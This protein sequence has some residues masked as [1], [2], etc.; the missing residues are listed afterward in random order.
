M[1]LPNGN[2]AYLDIL[3]LGGG[4]FRSGV[5]VTDHHSDPIEF[6]CTQVVHPNT[7][8]KALWGQRLSRHLVLNVLGY[9]LMESIENSLNV[10]FVSRHDFLEMRNKLGIPLILLSTTD[11]HPLP[12]YVEV[13]ETFQSQAKQLHAF[14][15]TK[16]REDWQIARNAL[17]VLAQSADVM[18][19]FGRI[20]TSLK[21]VTDQEKK[22]HGSGN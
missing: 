18:E 22:Q 17:S 2:I 9:P 20:A 15:H 5:L 21:L 13:A 16:F 10:L 1:E 4:S 19:P 14:T 8:Q 6:R 12:S 11:T 7:L 3:E